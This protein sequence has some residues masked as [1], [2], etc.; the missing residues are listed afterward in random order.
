MKRA[1]S[2]SAVEAYSGQETTVILNKI[3]LASR[4]LY[5]LVSTTG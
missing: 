2:L 1:S 4:R 3:D 5:V